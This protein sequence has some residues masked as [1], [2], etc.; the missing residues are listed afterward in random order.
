ME[1]NAKKRCR[2]SGR[3]G[4][5]LLLLSVLMEG[6]GLFQ[7]AQAASS[8]SVA[9]QIG[10]GET[11]LE[12]TIERKTLTS[13][14]LVTQSYTILK[15]DGTWQTIQVEG[16]LWSEVLSFLE[17]ENG[18]VDTVQLFGTKGGKATVSGNVLRSESRYAYLP[19]AGTARATQVGGRY[20]TGGQTEEEASASPAA[21]ET[22]PPTET[23]I[24]SAPTPTPTPTPST[25]QP[26]ESEA[27]APTPGDERTPTVVPAVLALWW[28]VVPDGE[29]LPTW[30]R[31]GAT[32]GIR[33][34]YG[35]SKKTEVSSTMM[36][37]ENAVGMR[38]YL[39]ENSSFGRNTQGLKLTVRTGTELVFEK[40]LSL[41]TLQAMTQRQQIY[42]SVNGDRKP[43]V[44]LAE[45]ILLSDLIAIT[46]ADEADIT[47][48]RFFYR[49]GMDS[50]F[51][52]VFLLDRTRYRYPR[53]F[54]AWDTTAGKPGSGAAA[55]AVPVEPLLALRSY[56]K[57]SATE[58]WTRLSDRMG[59]RICYGQLAPNDVCSTLYG[60]HIVKME[61]VL[62]P[63]STYGKDPSELVSP[64]P[65]DP[66]RG[67]A[68]GSGTSSQTGETI[69]KLPETLTLR[70][71]YFGTEQVTR[72]EFTLA[73]LRSLPLVK[74]AY[75]V[76]DGA[77]LTMETA[78]GVRLRD[79]LKAAGIDEGSVDS[80]TFCYTKGGKPAKLTLPKAFLLDIP[81]YYYPNLPRNWGAGGL[82]KPGAAVGAIQV[83]TILA[84][85][86]DW[87]EGATAPDFYSVK[88][89]HRFRLVFGQTGARVATAPSLVFW[90]NT[91]EVQLVG[92][93]A[94]SPGSPGG[95]I[96][97]GGTGGLIGSGTGTGGLGN[98]SQA[99]GGAGSLE[100]KTTEGGNT[101]LQAEIGK[102]EQSGLPVQS[103]GE[104]ASAAGPGGTQGSP[105]GGGQTNGSRWHLY[106]MNEAAEP[107]FIQSHSQGIWLALLGVVTFLGGG[108]ERYWE[109]RRERR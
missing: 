106:E 63:S 34:C 24:S 60:D 37:M 81:R 109:Y 102:G 43:E 30:H 19:A 100:E 59:F 87:S 62:K 101:T 41:E 103:E 72:K 31:A 66:T 14:P 93:P 77:N 51:S 85:K 88:S 45:G 73:E 25:S 52:K 33:L 40:N 98:G 21:T 91:I 80:F 6:T 57:G 42:T 96:G 44:T 82:P 104:T 84:L 54:D 16:V 94:D 4:V 17:I 64:T 108:A 90:I 67:D 29:A 70:V 55:G 89:N 58:D 18:D 32:E 65:Y 20:L 28:R 26:P 8:F 69:G 107:I 92:S 39:S 83:D 61:L 86:D 97:G 11:V 3:I 27:P 35:Q 22:V 78:V 9:V 46:G 7:G 13:L 1:R 105:G 76:P 95:L 47:N 5:I 68:T 48:L 12:Q 75:T 15:K 79:L 53:L 71:G 49:D 99:G 74:Q 50:S 38:L 36:T 10:E 23:P 56:T 2:A